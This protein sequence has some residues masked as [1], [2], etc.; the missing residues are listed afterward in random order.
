MKSLLTDAF[1]RFAPKSIKQVKG[2]SSPWITAEIRQLMNRRD[3]L[4]RKSR[5]TKTPHYRNAYKEIRNRV[6]VMIRNA[7][8][9]HAKNLL[10]ENQ[11][12]PTKFWNVIK[13]IYPSKTK[14]PNIE[15]S[16]KVDGNLTSDKTKIANGFCRFYTSAVNTLKKL[17]YPLINFV[18]RMPQPFLNRTEKVFAF[19]YVSVVEVTENLKKIKRKKATG[20]DDLPPGLLKNSTSSIARHV[21][22]VIN[23]SLRTGTFP[24]D[25]KIARLIPL[26][27]SSGARDEFENYRPISALP[28]ISKVIEKI[29]HRRVVEFL[30]A[31]QLLSNQQFRRKRSTELAAVAFT[32]DIRRYAD[33]KFLVGCLYIDFSKAFD[34][35]SHAKLLQKLPAY[36]IKGTALK[37]FSS[38]LFDRR[39]IVSYEGCSSEVGKVTCGVPQGSIL[40]P[41][42]FVIFTNDMVDSVKRC[43]IIKDADDTVLYIPGKNLLV[44][45][46]GLSSDLLSL[47]SWFSQN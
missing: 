36:G 11:K 22:F 17:A 5:K 34:T 21:A 42:L 45:E 43:K 33:K 13:S 27:K 4:L 44:I 8:A 12:D 14:L 31:N 35:V 40:S 23:L 38:Y 37:W 20:H 24:T 41:L 18:W 28:V 2:K 25:W 47:A 10:R 16:F 15:K 26:Y 19:T 1:N 9:N 7:K 29:V 46:E 32:D 3:V 30:D 39:Q 6:N